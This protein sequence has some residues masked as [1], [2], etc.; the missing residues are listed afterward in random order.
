[1]GPQSQVEACYAIVAQIPNIMN[2]VECIRICDEALAKQFTQYKIRLSSSEILE[3]IFEECGVE[4]A[5][6]IPILH[7]INLGTCKNKRVLDLLM[8]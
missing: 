4:L 3:C 2:E 5:D 6:R 8:I 7:Q 1:M